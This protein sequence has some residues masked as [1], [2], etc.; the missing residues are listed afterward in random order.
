MRRA[1]SPG[2]AAAPPEQRRDGRRSAGTIGSSSELSAHF[3]DARKINSWNPVRDAVRRS[4]PCT[5]TLS[6]T[7]SHRFRYTPRVAHRIRT[8]LVHTW[9]TGGSPG[10][11]ASR[12]PRSIPPPAASRLSSRGA[13]F[14]ATSLSL[15]TVLAAEW[16]HRAQ[17]SAG[18]R[19]QRWRRSGRRPP[20]AA[21]RWTWG[22]RVW[23]RALERVPMRSRLARGQAP[24]PEAVCSAISARPS[25]T[26]SGQ[27]R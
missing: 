9:R 18:E 11:P 3:D 23:E 14:R 22:P 25:G 8:L 6:H 26:C 17:G 13:R 4:L 15:P 20:S 24:V 16:S 19:A 5:H 21:R 1:P 12:G 10:P 27:I 2:P 7:H